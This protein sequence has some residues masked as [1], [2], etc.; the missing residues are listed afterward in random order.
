AIDPSSTQGWS[1]LGAARRRAGDQSGAADAFRRAYE[2]SPQ[3]SEA[4]GNLAIA[5]I[6]A[7]NWQ[8]AVSLLEQA[9]T[10]DPRNANRWLLLGRARLGT[11]NTTGAAAAFEAAIRQDPDDAGGWAS[12][13]AVQ[14]A[15]HYYNTGAF[16]L[17]LAQADRALGWRHDLVIGLIYQG[18]AREE[19]G[20]LSGARQSLEQAQQLEP[21]RA[22][23]YLN[24]GSV[25]Y[26]LGLFDQA[27]EAL[28]RA[29]AIQPD[30]PD[31]QANLQAVRAGRSL[32]RRPAANAAPPSPSRTPS[33]PAR[34][35]RLGVRF[36]DIDYTALGLKGAMVER[37]EAGGPAGRAGLEK[38]DLILRID[39]REV[40]NAE[41][42]QR[43]VATR[44]IGSRITLSLLRANVPVRIDVR[45][46]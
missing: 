24:L 22:A 16:Q 29:L 34:T 11:G 5:D 35:A 20:D 30:F 12:N 3:N 4:L 31:A 37:V 18:L 46:D 9:T 6:D 1:N 17:A 8:R 26:Q 21:T 15:Q 45:L 10:A 23:T 25:Y 2:L 38:N 27:I 43:Y 13:A 32:A 36:A 44:P 14:L 33:A 7:G 40:A 39:G 42:L 19:L 28:E 41:A